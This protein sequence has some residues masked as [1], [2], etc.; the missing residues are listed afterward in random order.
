MP[1]TR[2]VSVSNFPPAS[3]AKV[4]ASC[5]RRYVFHSARGRVFSDFST[6]W[7]NSGWPTTT[8]S[9]PS[10]CDAARCVRHRIE[11]AIVSSP[12]TATAL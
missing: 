4:W 7:K 11:G 2:K 6:A 5:Q 10:M 3:G 12:D 1:K 9:M 8:V